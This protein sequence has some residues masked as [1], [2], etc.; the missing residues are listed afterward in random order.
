MFFLKQLE[1]EITLQPMHFGPKMADI[2][3]Q[4]LHAE[5]EGTCTGRY[6]YIVCVTTVDDVGEGRILEGTGLAKFTIKYR[7]IV[8]RPFKGEVVD[9][10]VTQVNQMGFFA[11]VGPLQVFISN[12]V[13]ERKQ[14]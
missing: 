10:I 11:E 1:H 13:S 6:G 5:V 9:A 2:L 12:H 14:F 7:A 3:V 8:F 4:R